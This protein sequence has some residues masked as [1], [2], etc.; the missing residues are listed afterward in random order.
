MK[1]PRKGKSIVQYAQC[2]LY[3]YTKSYCNRPFI[4]V[5]CGGSH[6]TASCKIKAETPA[7]CALSS[8]L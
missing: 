4:C 6:S 3:G 5:K 1:P 8:K 7:T 2:Q